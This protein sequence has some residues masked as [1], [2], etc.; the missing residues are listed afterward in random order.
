MIPYSNRSIGHHDDAIISYEPNS[1]S[2]ISGQKPAYPRHWSYNDQQ[3]CNNENGLKA[4]RVT[5]NLHFWQ[6]VDSNGTVN[7][8]MRD[9]L[10]GIHVQSDGS[11]TRN[12]VQ[13]SDTEYEENENNDI[14]IFPSDTDRQDRPDI[15]KRSQSEVYARSPSPPDRFQHGQLDEN[16]QSDTLKEEGQLDDVDVCFEDEIV[17]SDGSINAGYLS[18][19]DNDI[20]VKEGGHVR[21]ITLLKINNA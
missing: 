7:D 9:W 20:K 6:E 10:S 18:R 1:L 8:V 16:H 13:G 15:H 19:P 2:I 14:H 5:E 21:K 3:I 4:S 17:G 12:A 11:G